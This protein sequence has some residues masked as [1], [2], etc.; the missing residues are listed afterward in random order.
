MSPETQLTNSI[1]AIK[2]DVFLSEMREPRFWTLYYRHSNIPQLTKG[3]K[4]EGSL[5]QAIR[6]G[7]DHCEKM[8][9]LFICVRPMIVDLDYQ[10]IVYA[11][12]QVESS[13]VGADI[14]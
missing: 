13:E 6:R 12:S 7:K 3:F 4:F 8:G 10:E 5:A 1:P 11:R 2:K 14:R 9:Y